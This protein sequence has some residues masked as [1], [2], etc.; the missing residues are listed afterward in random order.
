MRAQLQLQ[1][2][3]VPIA[4]SVQNDVRCRA[5]SIMTVDSDGFPATRSRVN[6][7]DGE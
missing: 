5:S 6:T 7:M 2:I 3:V 4:E 1:V